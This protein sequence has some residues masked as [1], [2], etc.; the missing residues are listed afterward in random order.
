MTDVEINFAKLFHSC[1]FWAFVNIDIG[2]GIPASRGVN[3]EFKPSAV[4]F[5]RHVLALVARSAF[6][7]SSPPVKSMAKIR[8]SPG[9]P[10]GVTVYS[11]GPMLALSHIALTPRVA[12]SKVIGSMANSLSR[13]GLGGLL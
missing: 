13:A 3:Q 8:E 9:F 6:V 7:L 12:E 4:L 1:K 10:N 11:V 5:L 2:F